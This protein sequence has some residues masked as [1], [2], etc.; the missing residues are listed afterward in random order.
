[1]LELAVT[2]SKSKADQKLKA[3]KLRMEQEKQAAQLEKDRLD[4]SIDGEVSNPVPTLASIMADRND[5][6]R[7][8][9]DGDI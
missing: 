5:I 1:M 4:G 3:L 8:I 6:M 9:K 2:A 7:R